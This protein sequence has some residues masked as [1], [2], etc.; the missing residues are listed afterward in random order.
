MLIYFR[1]I[2]IFFHFGVLN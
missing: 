2:I 1:F